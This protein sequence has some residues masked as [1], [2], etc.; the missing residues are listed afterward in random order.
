[1]ESKREDELLKEI[2]Y[3]TSKLLNIEVHHFDINFI[4][5]I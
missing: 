4:V 3:L 2:Q 1:M 5:V